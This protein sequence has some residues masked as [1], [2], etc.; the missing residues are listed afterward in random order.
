MSLKCSMIDL[1]SSDSCNRTTYGNKRLRT[2][3]IKMTH[4]SINTLSDELDV[5]NFL[6]DST[7]KQDSQH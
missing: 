6:H 5:I 3:Q 1:L 2:N 4:K 7:R